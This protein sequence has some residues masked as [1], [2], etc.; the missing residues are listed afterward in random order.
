[1]P[2]KSA[3]RLLIVDD[4]AR[5]VT[6]LMQTLSRQG[7]ATSGAHS[8]AEALDLL[9]A[10]P[11][12]LLLTDLMMPQTNGIE[13]LRQALAIDS[14]IVGVLMTGQGTIDTAVEAMK[15][16]AHDYILKPF[17]LTV[18]LP[19]LERALMTRWLRLENAA[20]V[21]GL[22]HR[23]AELEAAN[24]A[25]QSANKELDSFAHSISHDLRTPLNAVI[26]FAELIMDPGTGP[27]NEAQQMYLTHILE[28][29]TR[30]RDLTEALLRFARLGQQPL[31]KE[32]VAMQPMIEGIVA[33]LRAHESGRRVEVRIP[34]CQEALADPNLIR[35]VFYNLLS[36]AFKYTRQVEQPLVE[37]TV[38]DEPDA[39][40]YGIR[41][42]GA[43]FDMRDAKRLFAP[44]QRLHRQDQFEGTGVGLSLVKRII[45]RHGGHIAAV[46]EPG[47]GAEFT[48]TLPKTDGSV[49]PA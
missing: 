34:A 25:L 27:L 20:L 11:F 22:T 45:D 40:V 49:Q 14:H 24:Q 15:S 4:E 19:V 30:L 35:Q 8:A 26:G 47:K 43:G 37:I 41:D 18:I 39:Q 44:F 7:Y 29:G 1:M 10:Q 36:N 13:L 38:R 9:R 42:N 12:D 32:T 3:S 5:N 31:S 48:I 28:G 17:N 46:G 6:A 21:K 16:G 33:E 23:T 2:S